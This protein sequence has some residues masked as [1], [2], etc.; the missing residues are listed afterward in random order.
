MSAYV[1]LTIGYLTLDA[2]MVKQEVLSEHIFYIVIDLSYGIHILRHTNFAKTPFTK[3]AESSVP[4]FFASSTASLIAT[5][6]G[7][8]SS[9]KIS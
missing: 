4:Y 3:E 7:I 2:D 9:F 6:A 5:A 1:V 8:S